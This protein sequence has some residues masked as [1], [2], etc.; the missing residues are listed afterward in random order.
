MIATHFQTLVL[1]GNSKTTA[2]N[3]LNRVDLLRLEAT[4]KLQQSQRGEKGQFLTPSSVK[5]FCRLI[6]KMKIFVSHNDA[7]I[8]FLSGYG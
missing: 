5:I 8:D 2:S 7:K 4:Q 3:L 1:P 6:Q